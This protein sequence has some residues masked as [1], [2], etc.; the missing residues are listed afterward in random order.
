MLSDWLNRL[1]SNRP[2]NK[3]LRLYRVTETALSEEEKLLGPMVRSGCRARC[4]AGISD[5]SANLQAKFPA[6]FAQ[7][8][9]VANFN[10]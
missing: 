9:V 1:S 6:K 10:S 8:F 4:G 2:K 7:K 3:P 5:F